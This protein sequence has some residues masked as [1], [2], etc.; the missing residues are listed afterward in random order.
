MLLLVDDLLFEMGDPLVECIDV[1]WGAEPG[2]APRLFA[3]GLG[4]PLLELAN[5]GVEPGGAFVGG[6][7]VGL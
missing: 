4:E 6:E 7:Q 3:E 1:G 5:A 2:L